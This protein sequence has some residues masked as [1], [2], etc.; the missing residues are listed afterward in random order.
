MKNSIMG[1]LLES[2]K[3]HIK[4]A[5]S[6]DITIKG[7]YA[8][9]CPVCG[10]HNL[11]YGASEF[12]GDMMYFPWTCGNCG[13]NG[14]EW[15]DTTFAGHN[16]NLEDGNFEVSDLKSKV[17]ES[18]KE[19]D[20]TDLQSKLSQ[21][22]YDDCVAV[23]CLGGYDTAEEFLQNYDMSDEWAHKLIAYMKEGHSFVE[24]RTEILKQIEDKVGKETIDFYFNNLA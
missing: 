1:A 11:D 10:E 3:T 16:L 24:A 12:E 5:T 15:Y 21:A 22:Q 23:H 2:Q 17:A 19:S 14:E 6:T 13:M 4:E 18:I 9:A 8:G 7:N 20:T